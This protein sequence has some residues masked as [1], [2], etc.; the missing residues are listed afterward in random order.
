MLG[1]GLQLGAPVYPFPFGLDDI[2]IN[3]WDRIDKTVTKELDHLGIGYDCDSALAGLDGDIYEAL[4][5]GSYGIVWPTCAPGWVVKVTADPT[6]GPILSSVM[7]EP[8]LAGHPAIAEILGVWRIPGA[9]IEIEGE[10]SPVFVVLREEIAPIEVDD[11]EAEAINAWESS[12]P[13]QELQRVRYH[14]GRVNAAIPDYASMPKRDRDYVS[15][16]LAGELNEA[17][18][19]LAAYR[20][21]QALA[22]FMGQFYDIFGVALAD[23]HYGN[24]G[25]RPGGRE[26]VAFD[27]GHS[28]GLEDYPPIELLPNPLA[29]DTL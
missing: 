8:D 26:L 7:D 6:E 21:S 29:I 20:E 9:S 27:L 5:Y 3:E 22:D 23:I 4:G 11:E 15:S 13:L 14:A 12:G 28:Q 18:A 24:V 1:I 2:A 17:L 25:F 16:M 10:E 19:G